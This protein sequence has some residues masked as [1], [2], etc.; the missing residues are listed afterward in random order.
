MIMRYEI[1]KPEMQNGMM[2]LD[3]IPLEQQAECTLEIE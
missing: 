2:C 1:S 3:Q